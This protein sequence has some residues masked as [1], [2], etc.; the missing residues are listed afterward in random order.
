MD[1][2]NSKKTVLVFGVFDGLH[3]GHRDLFRQAVEYGSVVV[4]V[5]PDK[6]V[7]ELKGRKPVL[8]QE[9]R[10]KAIE[11]SKYASRAVL[12]DEIRGT[13]SAIGQYNPDII[14]VGYDQEALGIHLKKWMQKNDKM[15][16]E[17]IRLNRYER[18]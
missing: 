7:L 6:A 2:L 16:I 4:V 11:G 10:I 8:G 3:E 9:E 12:G 15:S 18:G 1:D 14:C 5:A 17:I 13:Y